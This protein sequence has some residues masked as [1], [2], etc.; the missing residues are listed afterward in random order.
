MGKIGR[1]GRGGENEYQNTYKKR[2]LINMQGEE[3]MEKL[4]R[5]EREERA[6][7]QQPVQLERA[8]LKGEVRKRRRRRTKERGRGERERI[9]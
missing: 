9:Q 7:Q 3:R 8:R 6:I 5:D 2:K 1:T 4:R